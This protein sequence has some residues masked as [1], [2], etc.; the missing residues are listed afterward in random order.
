MDCSIILLNYN[1][2]EWLEPCLRS[3]YKHI[4]GVNFEVVAVDNA[5][6]DGSAQMVRELFPQVNLIANQEN[7]YVAR[8]FNKGIRASKGKYIFIGDADLEFTDN[9]ISTMV[10]FMDKN[11]K[12][13]VL[14]CPFYYP[15]GE[16]FSKCY[17][18][19]HT[20]LFSLLNF[21]FLG[22]IFK[23]TLKKLTDDFAY[24]D[25]D[26]KSS[27]S[28]DIVDTAVLFRREA[29]DE[30]GLYDEKFYLY[31]VQNDICL[32]MRQAGWGLYY[33]YEGHLTHAQHQS[34]GKEN[35]K[36]ISALYRKDIGHYLFKRFGLV[37]AGFVM[38]LLNVTRYTVTIAAALGLFKPKKNIAFG[39]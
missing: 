4:S 26:R 2:K 21:T 16:F 37:R 6:S 13:A 18:R 31:A 12:I 7:L 34:V 25:W 28:V 30:V 9:L 29:L 27:R 1:T 11:P 36:K 15:N 20:Y 35:W 3:I 19:D 38:F 33:L 22:K 39:T 17:S 32:R 5:S 24:A 23:K 8:G 14:G 10:Q